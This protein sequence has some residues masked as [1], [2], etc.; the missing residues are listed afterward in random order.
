MLGHNRV[1]KAEPGD[2]TWL[3]VAE[4]FHSIQGE[5]PYAGWPAVFIRLTGCNLRCWWCDTEWDD[6]TDPYVA[7]EDIVE[8][9]GRLAQP[10][11]KLAVV[12]GGEPLR[13]P[14]NRL[15]RAL[16]EHGFRPQIETAGTLWQDCVAEPYVDIVVSPKTPKIHPKVY[17]AALAFKYVIRAGEVGDD[18]LPVRSTQIRGDKAILARP[19]P[20]AQVFLSPCD[21]FDKKRNRANRRAVAQ[22]ALKHGYRAGVQLHKIMELP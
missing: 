18:G 4:I 11:T 13:Q 7:V 9:A 1:R 8:Q 20:G 3:Q 14:L 12:T 10:T 5:G 2:G 21:E 19:R 22:S 6:D 15:L 16:H 17:E